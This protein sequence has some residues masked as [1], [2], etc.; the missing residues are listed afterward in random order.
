MSQRQ[1]E[2]C[3]LTAVRAALRR[4]RERGAED[5]CSLPKFSPQAGVDAPAAGKTAENEFTRIL[6]KVWRLL[7]LSMFSAC[8]CSHVCFPSC[9]MGPPTHSVV[10]TCQDN[11]KQM[12]VVGQFN[13]GFIIGQLGSDLF[14]LV[15]KW[16]L[17]ILMSLLACWCG[18]S[19]CSLS[20]A[21]SQDQHACDEKIQ[22]EGLQRTTTIHEQRLMA[23]VFA[24]FLSS[25]I[26]G[27]WCV[28]SSAVLVLLN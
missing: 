6:T 8:S 22:F 21:A 26:R 28:L 4:K 5:S 25:V 15:R 19:C 3:D 23:Y 1:V 13:L 18:D 12:R 11:F 24:C 10:P 14:I 7:L 2:P 27:E 16:R 17:N 20:C 9:L